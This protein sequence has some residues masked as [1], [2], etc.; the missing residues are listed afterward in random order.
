MSLKKKV[1]AFAVAAA[2]IVP[3]AACGSNGSSSSEGS[4][5]E[6][7]E[8][9]VWGW[10]PLL[11]EVVPGF[12]KENP[13]IKVK[14]TNA[15]TNSKEYTALS[16]A[17]NAGSGAPDVVQLDYN[18]VPQF[19]LT[20]GLEDLSQYG[21]G[22]IIDQFTNGAKS[23]VTIENKVYGLP[24]GTGPMALFYNKD[25]FDKAGVTE[26]PKTWDEFYEAAKKI[27]KTG[28][29][30]TSD[31]GDAGFA[32]SMMWEAGGA[33]FKVDGENLTINLTGDSGVQKFAD[34][35]QKMISEDLIDTQ[36]AGWSED[37][38]K[39]L[40]D[41]S[42]AS[43]MTGAWMPITLENSV[44]DAAGKYR[45]AALPTPS[46]EAVSSE[47]GGG[48]LA[49]VKGTKKGDAAYKFAKYVAIGGGNKTFTDGGSFPPDKATLENKD[50]LDKKVD[51][52]GG[53]QINK[54]LAQSASDVKTE[55]QFLPFQVYANDV[56]A[57]TVGKAYAKNSTT[58]LKDGLKQWQDKLVA[59]GKEQ[60]YTVNQ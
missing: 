56:F 29:Y 32:M 59:Y 58:T 23:A 25:V 35:W 51:Y 20:G 48:A 38:Y 43:L 27:R 49:V 18:A 24:M 16:N 41:G 8:L 30:I 44:K 2:M 6:T 37:W 26:A 47:N 39:S 46:G 5:G 11:K 53:Q 22:D 7:V 55:F 36:T 13:N 4:N 40:N 28:S 34:F 57:D 17:L 42:I 15:G 52:F 19:A 54:V 14:I 10:E 9:N 1:A 33:P 12:E 21:S 50:F 31:S 60:G 3:L 45:V